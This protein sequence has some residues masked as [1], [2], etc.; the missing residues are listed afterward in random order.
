MTAV[1]VDFPPVENGLDYLK[2]VVELLAQGEG[3]V[4]PR[5]LKYAV[6]HLQAATEVLLKYRLYLEHWTLVLQDLD[7]TRK[8]P[9]KRVTR[10]MFDEGDFVSCSPQETLLR[11]RTVVG[12]PI[13]PGDEAE[14]VSLA[15]SRNALQHYGLTDSEGTIETRT[16]AVLDFLIRFLDEHLLPELPPEARERFE[17]DVELIRS[18]L[19]YI[20]SFVDQRMERLKD[21]L[22]P[23]RDRTVQCPNCRQW[24]LVTG[25]E[26]A[27]CLFCPWAADP[28]LYA[29]DY[30]VKFLDVPWRITPTD[31]P[32]SQPAQ[33]PIDPCPYCGEEA[34]VPGVVTAAAPD[35]PV[36]FCFA[37]GV[38]LPF[39]DWQ[40]Q[41]GQ[42]QPRGR[43]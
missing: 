42:R 7:L 39:E 29:F 33:P 22:G 16:V 11:L 27:E 15:K 23:L 3:G 12:L 30:V 28:K 32:F 19:T 18:G 13:T 1:R 6:L 5:N 17:D 26:L 34:A 9:K 35:H 40:G 8:T 4:S 25:G 41:D 21:E 38:A 20:R 37:C 43:R 36:T 14:I 2:S 24:A 31:G 10:Q